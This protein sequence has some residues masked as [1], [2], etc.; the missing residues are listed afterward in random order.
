MR[1]Q[2]T[3]NITL[4]G[5]FG[6]L[7]QIDGTLKKTCRHVPDLPARYRSSCSIN[8]TVAFDR[9]RPVA[10]L[11]QYLWITRIATF[12]FLWLY[13][14]ISEY[15]WKNNVMT[16]LPSRD[17]YPH[18]TYRGIYWNINNTARGKDFA[19]LGVVVGLSRVLLPKVLPVRVFP[20]WLT[21]RACFQTGFPSSKKRVSRGAPR[22]R[23]FASQT[24]TR[25]VRQITRVH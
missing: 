6:L 22:E 12:S 17:Y 14:C 21:R 2:L 1:D 24:N 18:I 9:G 5:L 25:A 16:L 11:I 3:P 4:F 10:I 19:C 20:E 13:L 8:F 23:E 7:H 15:T